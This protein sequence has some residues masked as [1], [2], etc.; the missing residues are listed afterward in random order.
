VSGGKVVVD[1]LTLFEQDG[2]QESGW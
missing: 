2:I 1:K